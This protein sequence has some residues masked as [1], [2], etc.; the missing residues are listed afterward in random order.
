MI[1]EASES[2]LYAAFRGLFRQRILN[3][4]EMDVSKR[5]VEFRFRND[6]IETCIVQFR[7]LGLIRESVKQ[8]SVKDT[9]TYW[10]LTPWGD[11]LMTT[12]RAVRKG[13]K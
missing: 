3:E 2:D 12:L 5:T 9:N 8:R 6:Q 13:T 7:A 11:H 1:S 4:V 10:K